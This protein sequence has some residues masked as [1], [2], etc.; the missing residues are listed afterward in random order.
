M[1]SDLLDDVDLAIAQADRAVRIEWEYAT[2]VDRDSPLVLAI[3]STLGLDD[4]TID[5][6]FADASH[7]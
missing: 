5:Q 2:V 7:R 3:G 4:S 1:A 6:L